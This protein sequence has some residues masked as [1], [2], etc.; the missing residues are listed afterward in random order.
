[1]SILTAIMVLAGSVSA[2]AALSPEPCFH[3]EPAPASIVG[4]LVVKTFPGPPNYESVKAGDRRETYW[5]VELRE[6]ICLVG[7]PGDEVNS[8]SVNGVKLVQL[9][10]LHDEYKS[11]GQLVGKKVQA[12]GTFSVGI[13]GHHHTPVL[14]SITRLEG[15]K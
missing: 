5:F 8:Q 11:H 4:K 7:T 13:S 12:T 1:M 10:L 3:F 14:L 9:L 15:A 2:N 6:P